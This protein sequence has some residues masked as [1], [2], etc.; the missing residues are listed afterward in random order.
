MKS[1]SP[2]SQST[3]P[4]LAG[5]QWY[6]KASRAN[7]IPSSLVNMSLVLTLTFHSKRL[8]WSHWHSDLCTWSPRRTPHPKQAPSRR[9]RTF[10]VVHLAGIPNSQCQ[11][12]PSKKTTHKTQ[13]H[14]FLFL[15][16]RT[17]G[18]TPGTTAVTALRFP[19]PATSLTFSPMTPPHPETPTTTI[20]SPLVNPHWSTTAR[21]LSILRRVTSQKL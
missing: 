5:S 12:S 1:T 8:W 15:E 11:R 10:P 13:H 6:T 4:L 20:T 18:G 21:P 2:S 3:R 19:A 9:K 17:R 16:A 7:D 14:L